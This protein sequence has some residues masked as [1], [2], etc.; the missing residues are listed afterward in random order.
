MTDF[1]GV[2]SGFVG[3]AEAAVEATAEGAE[4]GQAAVAIAP[5]STQV[6]SGVGRSCR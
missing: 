3:D 4:E 2:Q 6:G 1:A 5:P